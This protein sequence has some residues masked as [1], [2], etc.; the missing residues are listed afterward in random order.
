MGRKGALS[1]GEK[2][3]I[4]QKLNN[5][6]STLEI[7]KELGRDHRTIKKFVTNPD[8]CNCRSDKEKRRKKAP[9]SHR[10]M[11]RITREC[12]RNPRKTSK[13]VFEN[14]GVPNVP[15]STRCRILREVGKCG[16]PEVRP[17]IKDIH[18]QKRMDW[19]KNH[20]KVNFQTVLF[21]DECRA[22]LDGPD[23]W[24]RGWYCKD[25]PRPYQ[26]RRQQ[27]GE[28]VMF[29]A[30]IIGNE[31]VAPFKVADGVKI[32]AKLYIKFIKE[33]LLFWYKMKSLAFRKDMVFMYDNAPSN[34]A[35][36]TTEYLES[37]FARHGKIMQWPACS[38]DIN[39]IENLWS[40]LKRKIHSGGR[41]YT[42][43][44]G[45]WNAVL[46]AVK[47]TS[48]DEIKNL[49]SS[50]DERLFSFVNEHGNFNLKDEV[51]G[52]RPKKLDLELLE[53]P[54]TENLT[55]TSR[56]LANQFDVTHITVLK[57]KQESLQSWLSDRGMPFLSGSH[58]KGASAASSSHR[59]TNMRLAR[60]RGFSSARQ[61][62]E[63]ESHNSLASLKTQETSIDPKSD[64]SSSANPQ[65][66]SDVYHR[67]TSV[68]TQESECS[69]A[70]ENNEVISQSPCAMMPVE[71]DSKA[72]S[73]MCPSKECPHANTGKAAP[74][75]YGEEIFQGSCGQE[76]TS[77]REDCA[78]VS[79]E[80]QKVD[81]DKESINVNNNKEESRTSQT[82]SRSLEE[83]K[84]NE[85]AANVKSSTEDFYDIENKSDNMERKID[86]EFDNP[87]SRNEEKELE[88]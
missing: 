55:V 51:R 42:S 13:E 9:V 64:S 24:R 50:M 88:R 17:P 62:A 77:S 40:I 19:A 61:P 65:E 22:T 32:T 63:S 57:A 82:E 48:S 70:T 41:Q 18:E 66:M 21:T 46:T 81:S 69:S 85:N 26:I 4:V 43:K 33:H 72:E 87:S 79:I 12:R 35:R 47:E 15:R 84:S 11:S 10:A 37:V 45:L 1:H 60:A 83:T 6:I 68:L 7:A 53:A 3:K 23:G 56:E 80:G 59:V 28:G 67:E 54:L 20:M 5:N 29:W 16:K 44:D 38:L 74:K 36:I 8:R 2:F 76:S 14:A 25:G 27:G 49:T 58:L 31:L 78:E 39:P 71:K 30:A 73:D 52:G 75:S 34:A 86:H